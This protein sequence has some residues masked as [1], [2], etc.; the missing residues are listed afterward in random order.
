MLKTYIPKE[1]DVRSKAQHVYSHFPF[2]I[3]QTVV[4]AQ[5]HDSWI[6]FIEIL[7]KK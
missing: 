1:V 7:K 5:I 2:L 4:A 6:F 3:Q